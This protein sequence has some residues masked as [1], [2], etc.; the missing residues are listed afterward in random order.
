[1]GKI[2]P[3]DITFTTTFSIDKA[4]NVILESLIDSGA[5]IKIGRS[6]NIVASFGSALKVRMLGLFICGVQAFPRDL[7]VALS[8]EDGSTRIKVTVDDTFGFGSRAGFTV[9]LQRI[10]CEDASNIKALFD[11]TN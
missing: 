5:K 9:S 4:R 2:A 8:N 6:A 11:A 1:M 3:T 10:M 7:V